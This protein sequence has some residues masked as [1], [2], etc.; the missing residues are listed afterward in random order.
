MRAWSRW[1]RWIGTRGRGCEGV[2]LT[3]VHCLMEGL[4]RGS[5]IDLLVK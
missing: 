4:V 2:G 1:S 5:G 3:R